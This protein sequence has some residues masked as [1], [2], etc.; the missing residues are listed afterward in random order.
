MK[1]MLRLQ[2]QI[3]SAH[4][5]IADDAA[6]AGLSVRSTINLLTSQS[7]DRE[8]NGFLDNDFRNYISA[9]R[10]TEMI[11]GDG[12]AIMEYFHKMQL[13][14][15]SCFYLVRFD[16]ADNF[17]LNVF[18]ADGRSI[19]DYQH[20][21]DVI[22]FDTTYRTN[23]Y[24]RPAMSG[25]QPRTILTDQCPAMAKAIEEVFSETHHRLCVW[26]IYQNAAKNLSHVFHSSKQF[27]YDFSS[28]VYGY[29]EEDKWLQAWDD[30]LNK[31]MLT[32]NT[33]CNGIFEVRRKWA[34]VCGRHMFTADMMSTQRSESMNNVLKKYL[35]A[36]NNFTHF[37]DNYNRLLSD[38]RY[39]VQCGRKDQEHLVTL[40]ALTPSVK[41]NCMKF[42][43]V[44]ILCAH[45]LKT[46][47][48][49]NIKQ[50]SP[51]YILKRWTRD[52]KIGMI[53]DNYIIA[54]GSS[55]Q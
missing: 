26:H 28:R 45:T 44:G 53:E 47:D 27:A 22:C 55:P 40:D 46:L 11:R 17:I 6:K 33:W 42:T 41:C 36:K 35:D 2:R 39:K 48:K 19:I 4:K 18:W 49:K 24:A 9:K 52:A 14:D 31:Y 10:R 43:F 50:I 3:T 7:G 8:F 12:H 13:Q 34:M 23:E 51:Q 25:K 54:V 30:M 29:E 1:H 15:P 5:V 16:D 37:F 38:K 32:D 21:G 20:F